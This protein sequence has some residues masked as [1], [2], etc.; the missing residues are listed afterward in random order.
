MQTNKKNKSPMK[1]AELFKRGN[2]FV[3][4]SMCILLICVLTWPLSV[5]KFRSLASVRVITNQSQVVKAGLE[6][7]VAVIIESETTDE[8]LAEL[9]S[10]VA[11]ME[12][13]RSTPF[14]AKDFDLIRERLKCA[15]RENEL[16]YDLELC[17]EG[18]GTADELE[19]VSLLA[20]RFSE[21]L[22]RTSTP[23][24]ESKAQLSA[25]LSIRKKQD[26]RIEMAHWL[27]GEAEKGIGIARDELSSAPSG[28]GQL[29]S[30]P[31]PSEKTAGTFQLASSRKKSSSIS[32]TEEIIGEID[33]ASIK[34]LFNEMKQEAD[35]EARLIQQLVR[36]SATKTSEAPMM[37]AEPTQG[38]TS[39]LNVAPT[40]KTFGL[41]GLVSLSLGLVVAARMD[42]FAAR[43]FENARSIAK[44]L[45]VPVVAQIRWQV[46]N[47]NSEERLPSLPWANRI[48]MMCGLALLG[49]GVVVAG[50]VLINPAVRTAFYE[51]PL[52]GCSMI[53]RIF[54]GF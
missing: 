1:T 17:I 37:V 26:E 7:R 39:P 13:L 32:K 5:S 40:M 28:A 23:K 34:D 24:N 22:Q 15:L 21:K 42:P 30:S 20:K 43:G 27:L 12:R 33:L 31:E 45:E 14:E 54:V 51:D 50:F 47:F 49:I 41:L 11:R 10:K 48:S 25:I 3:V 4:T 29:A 6:E 2:A 8:Q 53:V 9:L 19:F 16:G 35:S 52:V 36:E 44:R 46:K 18:R 38:V